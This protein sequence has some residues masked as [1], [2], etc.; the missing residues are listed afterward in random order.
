MPE[1][2]PSAGGDDHGH[3]HDHDHHAHGHEHQ[4]EF[5]PAR[6]AGIDGWTVR[7]L[8]PC[9]REL[10]A[11]VPRTRLD[12]AAEDVA[13]SIA[14][15][16]SLKGFRPGKVPVARVKTLF[17]DDIR[18]QATEK[19]VQD[20]WEEVATRGDVR[21]VANPVLTEIDAREGEPVRFAAT[22]EVLPNVQLQ[23][24]DAITATAK[25]VKVTDQDVETEI[26]GLRGVRAKLVDSPSKD[27]S[28][29]D[30]AII[31]LRRWAPGSDRSDEPAE[32]RKE[33]LVEVG[34]ERN[35]PELDKALLGMQAGETRNFE[36]TVPDGSGGETSAPFAVTL[37]AIKQRRL[38]DLDDEFVKSLGAGLETV[39][40][41]K[42]DIRSRLVAIRTEAARH[43]QE[44]EVVD[45]LLAKNPVPM[46][47]T[48]VEKESEARLRRGVEQLARRGVDVE[49]ASI[50]W[51]TE[52]EKIRASAERDLRV[53]WL[54]ELASR[55]KGVEVDDD[56]VAKALDEL[57]E[58]RRIPP[59]A[60]R[61]ELEKAKKMNDFRAQVRRR[62]TLDL[63][64]SGAT[65]SVE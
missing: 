64:R 47:D 5:D 56:D 34:N 23:G 15:R 9:S 12:A 60:V 43:E 41:L 2:D 19:L 54:L 49:A 40:D 36:A 21:P 45:Q 10:L 37:T 51:K 50:D 20:V 7:E 59:A 28:A 39:A 46:P 1:R 24:L 62:R 48:L 31:D 11:S 52:F 55:A 30:V 32:H 63:L 42:K 14:R 25:T 33:L 17:A 8:S 3:D 35:V 61:L 58:A 27:A 53:D 29:G 57:A 22:F 38:P 26:E 44:S 18:R 6:Y 65:I 13:R 16:A 4:R